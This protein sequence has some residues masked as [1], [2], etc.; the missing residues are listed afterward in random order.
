[1]TKKDIRLTNEQ[2]ELVEENLAFAMYIAKRHFSKT[3]Y[4]KNQDIFQ[5][6]V[7]AM[8]YAMPRYDSE[9]AKL[10]TFM[11]PTIN[12]HLIRYTQYRDRIIPLPHQ[13]Y[14]KQETRDKADNAKFILSLD[15]KY[16]NTDNEDGGTL[17]NTL[18]GEEDFEQTIVNKMCIRDAI[19][20]VLDWR[21]KL[22]ITY[23][24]YFDLNQTHIGK[25]M[26]VSQVHCHRLEYRALE[27]IKKYLE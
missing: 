20:N 9:K 24:F 4:L 3:D 22:V 5:E 7:M 1:M 18:A 15:K 21:E 19:R 25:L 23:R 2:R 6:A 13:K 17:L 8:A 14:L 12:G 26:G 10:S 27:K 11:F 16:A